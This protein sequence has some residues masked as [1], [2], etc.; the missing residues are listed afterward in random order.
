MPAELL[1][2]LGCILEDSPQAIHLISEQHIT[3]LV[4]LL[5]TKGRDR[6]VCLWVGSVRR[7]GLVQVSLLPVL[8]QVV[9]FLSSLCV[10]H[11]VAIRDKQR[12]IAKHL[13]HRKDLF[14]HTSTQQGVV[15]L[16][17]H[18]GEQNGTALFF[19][20]FYPLPPPPPFTPSSLLPL[21]SSFPSLPL[22]SLSLPS[23]FS[24]PSLSL[25]PLPLPVPSPPIP[26]LHLP[27]PFS[28][29]NPSLPTLHPHPLPSPLPL[30][31]YFVK[32]VFLSKAENSAL[33]RK[34]YFEVA[35][36]HHFS[37]Q[38]SR[39]PLVRVGWAHMELF[40]PFPSSNGFQVTSGAVGHDLFSV[41]CD[42]RSV[43]VGECKV[44]ERV[45]DLHRQNRMDESDGNAYTV[46][47][48]VDLDSSTFSFSCNG[49]TV[50][51]AVVLP[52]MNLLTP[53]I[54]VSGGVR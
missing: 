38:F 46:G 16:E 45:Q 53:S 26:S 18:V 29:P 22:P 49:H 42:G 24:P 35:V 25:L 1:D 43:W 8:G 11:G 9:S 40:N 20:S 44:G 36:K 10:L 41:G 17:D 51:K 37:Q 48:C 31:S 52:Q 4:D 2:L 21:P 39:K 12:N 47:C 7:H 33:S 13:L 28:F 54:S 15:R 6:K 50:G 23:P 30:F 5:A 3:L 34:W 19:F 32:P 27:N 14:L